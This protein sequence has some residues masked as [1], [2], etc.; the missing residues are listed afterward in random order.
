MGDGG[1]QNRRK[2]KGHEQK[3]KKRKGHKQK[4]KEKKE[5]GRLRWLRWLRE[6]K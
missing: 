3:K 4:K 2:R 5:R 6:G 1:A